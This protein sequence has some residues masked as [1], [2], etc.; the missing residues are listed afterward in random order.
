MIAIGAGL[1]QDVDEFRRHWCATLVER[2]ESF[3]ALIIRI[4][5]RASAVIRI[6]IVVR[7]LDPSVLSVNENRGMAVPNAIR[8]EVS[9]E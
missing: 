8:K 9:C 4:N 7:A 3:V 2:Q 5:H 6:C 1:R